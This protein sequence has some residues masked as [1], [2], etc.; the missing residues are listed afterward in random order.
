[1]VSHLLRLMP[2]A[3]NLDLNRVRESGAKS[4]RKKCDASLN[5]KRQVRQ[6]RFVLQHCILTHQ[7]KA[8]TG[9]QEYTQ[10]L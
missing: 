2:C 6:M 1:M 10:H 8:V 5:G 9:E 7:K 3:E 4:L